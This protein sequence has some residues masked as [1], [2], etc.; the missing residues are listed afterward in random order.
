MKLEQIN[1]INIG[2]IF[3]TPTNIIN[4]IA[5]EMKYRWLLS[6]FARGSKSSE[7]IDES[8]NVDNKSTLVV[9]LRVY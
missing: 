2:F 1:G 6:I 3:V 7:F 4:H 5:K 8:T 9:Y